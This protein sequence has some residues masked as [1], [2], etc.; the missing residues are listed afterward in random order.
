MKNLNTNIHLLWLSLCFALAMPTASAQLTVEGGFTAEQIV[1]Q[2]V[3]TG[4]QVSNVVINCPDVAYGTFNGEFSNIGINSGIILTSGDINAAPGPNDSGSAGAGNG[5]PGDPDL[6]PLVGSCGGGSAPSTNDACVL[7]FDLVPYSTTLSFNYVFGSEEYEEYIDSFNDVF[8]FFITGGTEYP[9][10]TNIALVPGTSIPVSINNVNAGNPDIPGD[11]GDNPEYYVGNPEGF[12]TTVQYDG[13]TTVLTAF[14]TVTPCET[15]HLKLAI[16]DACDGVFDSGVFLE[17]N[18]LSTNYVEIEASAVSLTGSGFTSAVEGCVDGLLTFSSDEPFDT[19]FPIEFSLSGTAVQG[20]DYTIPTTSTVIPAG[21]STITV[22]IT[23]IEDGIAEGTETIDITFVLDLACGVNPIVQN[24]TLNLEDLAPVTV[25]SDVTIT[26]GQ[27]VQLEATGGSGTYTWTPP[28]GLSNANIANP[29]ATPIQTTTYTATS[30][31]GACTVSDQMTI[32]IQSCDPAT[33]PNAG[34]VVLSEN[35]ICA[36]G[37]AMAIAEG[38]ALNSPEDV[39]VFILHNSSANDLSAP[40]F[41]LYATNNTGF[42]DNVDSYP[43]NTPLYI[44]SIAGDNDGT[45]FPDLNDPCISISP[46][47]ELVFLDPVTILVDEMCDWNATPNGIFYV[48]VEVTGGLPAY[49]GGSY[50]LTGDL[51]GSILPNESFTQAFDGSGATQLY[52][53]SATDG[54][55][56]SAT[57]G[58]TFICYKTAIELLQYSGEVKEAGN[59]LTWK[60]ASETESDYFTLS[61]ATDGINFQNIATLKAAGNSLN[62]QTYSYI[63]R[64]APNGT[65]YYRLSETD[66]NGTVNNLGVVSLTRHRQVGLHI[67]TISPVPTTDIANIAFTA[68]NGNQIGMQLYDVTGRVV[69]TR[70]L[71]GSGSLQ[72]LSLDMSRYTS[73]IYFVVLNNGKEV[74]TERIMKK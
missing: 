4:V 74:A 68:E 58:N 23:M 67:N 49:E 8:A 39:Q 42:F 35:R 26:P 34:T 69:E 66:L 57:A 31:V 2:L 72:T 28:L 56:C 20:V 60:T 19:D 65:A 21:E 30:Q 14:A 13:F 33:D 15:Y 1:E 45:G 64:Q 61:R 73:G 41:V 47:E 63:D 51:N 71:I 48:T 25:N 11:T 24:V 17:A 12:E 36:N 37:T 18:S 3:G 59:E 22:P 16:A 46:A 32:T 40:D 54:N 38:L 6:D 50:V 7:E 29:V 27:S 62:A 44:T 55:S 9:A 70:N 52:S 10:A 53:L 5:A 43:T